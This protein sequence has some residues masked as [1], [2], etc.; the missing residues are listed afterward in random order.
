[1]NKVGVCAYLKSFF[2]AIHRIFKIHKV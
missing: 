2:K 1:M